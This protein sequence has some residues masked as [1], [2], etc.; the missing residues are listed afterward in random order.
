MALLAVLPAGASAQQVAH[1]RLQVPDEITQPDLAGGALVYR[2]PGPRGDDLKVLD[3]GT[4]ARVL[5]YDTGSADTSIESVR[6]VPGWVAIGVRSKTGRDGLATGVVTFAADSSGPRFLTAS[7]FTMSDG[8][9]GAGCG[10]VTTLEDLTAEGVVV[11]EEAVDPC[12]RAPATA[13][14]IRTYGPAGKADIWRVGVTGALELLEDRKRATLIGGR[15]L[16]WSLESARLVRLP[17][18]SSRVVL[19][20]AGR[21]VLYQADAGGTGRLVAAE[22]TV[23]RP[24]TVARVRS[25]GEGARPRGGTV[26]SR[27]RTRLPDVR[28]CGDKLVVWSVGPDGRQRVTVRRP[29]LPSATYRGAARVPAGKVRGFACDSGRYALITDTGR[30][31]ATVDVFRLP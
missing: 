7:G 10:G 15:L 3:L 11:T 18:G 12:D 29:G 24:G 19:P 4:G 25:I 31:R 5:L 22:L 6:A 28:F 26:L 8:N 13:S 9:G 1:S 30:R 17:S 23:R 20:S 16:I 2:S 27:S 21:T 14:T